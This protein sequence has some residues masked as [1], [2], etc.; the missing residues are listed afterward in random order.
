MKEMK[1]NLIKSF[2]KKFQ[3]RRQINEI[4]TPASDSSKEFNNVI[5][6]FKNLMLDD[7]DDSSA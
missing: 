4:C 5:T 3:D 6:E 1:H 7:S 2:C